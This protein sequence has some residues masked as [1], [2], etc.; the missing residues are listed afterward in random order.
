MANELQASV[1]TNAQVKLKKKLNDIE[2]R[3]F[4]PTVMEM[5]VANPD[6]SDPNVDKVRASP[7]RTVDIFY[8]K[9]LAA[10]TATSKAYN[11]TGDHIDTAK[12]NVTWVQYA[13]KLQI[14]AKEA[15][16][17][18]MQQV[19]ILANGLEMKMKN[20][21]DRHDIAALSYLQQTRMQRDISSEIAEIGRAHV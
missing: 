13:E 15:A 10:G 1:L 7:L 14:N 11:H 9:N 3:R 8:F 12:A 4:Q 19:D 16:N 5:A 6:L 17:N 2:Q 18:F 20:L 21:K